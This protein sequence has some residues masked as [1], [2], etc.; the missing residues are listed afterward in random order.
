MVTLPLP[1]TSATVGKVAFGLEWREGIWRG[2]TECS[3]PVGR[4]WRLSDPATWRHCKTKYHLWYNTIINTALLW[5]LKIIVWWGGG[6]FLIRL[7]ADFSKHFPQMVKCSP[8]CTFNS[9]PY[10][11]M[12]SCLKQTDSLQI[13]SLALCSQSWIEFETQRQILIIQ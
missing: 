9:R 2:S 13:L 1:V 5:T 8:S 10:P 11:I 7:L 4:W 6:D 3:I 12:L